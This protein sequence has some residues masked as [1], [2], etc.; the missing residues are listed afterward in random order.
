MVFKNR[1]HFLDD[2][3]LL[4]MF[5]TII[6]KVVVCSS[7]TYHTTS[8]YGIIVLV[9]VLMIFFFKFSISQMKL[10]MVWDTSI[11]WRTSYRTS[12]GQE[13][14][15]E[16]LFEY[17]FIFPSSLTLDPFFY[18][19]LDLNCTELKTEIVYGVCLVVFF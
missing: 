17:C 4:K 15:H 7:K 10:K 12:I 6:K 13:A 5:Q 1:R 14:S 9:T 2:W 16:Q 3:M 18:L 11:L 19:A 8:I